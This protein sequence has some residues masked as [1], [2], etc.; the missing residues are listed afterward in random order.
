MISPFKKSIHEVFGNYS[1]TKSAFKWAAGL[2]AYAIIVRIGHGSAALAQ[3][4]LT[5]AGI[6]LTYWLG[7][8]IIGLLLDS[9]LR[10]LRATLRGHILA[11]F[12]VLVPVAIIAN[13]TVLPEPFKGRD[14][15]L[16]ALLV[17]L[18]LGCSCGVVAWYTARERF[19]GEQG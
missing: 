6:L 19:E 2:S 12:L 13:W 5:L 8:T 18:F 17:G 16:F 4:N 3:H 10:S 14:L 15:V 7:A 1:A 11:G 9:I